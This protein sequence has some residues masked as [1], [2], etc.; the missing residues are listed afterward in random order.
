MDKTLLIDMETKNNSVII[1][2]HGD[3]DMARSPL[4]RDKLLD[5]HKSKPARIIIDLENVPYM[6]SSGVATLVEALQISRKN[7]TRL[8][9]C[10]LQERV[11]SIFEI[12][13]LDTVFAIHNDLQEAVNT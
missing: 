2:P 7:Q 8:L 13:R 1:R 9:L 6:D 3:I 4:F 10:N 12:A 11:I 5:V